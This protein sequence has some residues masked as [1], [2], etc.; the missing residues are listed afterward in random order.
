[1]PGSILKAGARKLIFEN[2]PKLL[3]ISL[4]YVVFNTIISWLS[5]RLPGIVSLDDIYSRLL[6]GEPPGLHIIYTGF[7]PFGALLALLIFLLRPVLNIGFISYCLRITRA[8]SAGFKNLLIGFLFFFKVIRLF[9]LMTVFILFWSIFLIIPGIVASYRYRLS[10][11]I[12]LDDPGKSAL[13]CIYESK[14]IMHGAKLDLLI[15][16]ISFLGW[17][18]LDMAILMLNPFPFALPIVSIWLSPYA[19]LTRAAFY[20]NRIENAAA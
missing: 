2:V 7:K 17:Y 5:Y 11:Y 10:Y 19:G 14:L 4:V 13:Q 9:L 1:M 8:Q 12:L 3:Y 20:E 6:D 16:D 15:I 18:V